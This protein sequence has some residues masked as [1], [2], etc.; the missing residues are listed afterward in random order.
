[1]KTTDLYNKKSLC[2]G[3]ELCSNVCPKHLII[4]K[5]DDE[6]FLY[7]NIINDEDCINCRR[8]LSV[9]PFKSPGRKNVHLGKS[10][11]GHFFNESEIKKSSSGGYATAISRGFILNGGMVIGVRYS[12]DFRSAEYAIVDNISDLEYFRTSKYIQALKG[13]V[14]NNLKKYRDRKILF[15]GLPCEVSAVYHCV[16][17]AVNNLYTISLICH[18]PTSCKIQQEFCDSLE[19]KFNSP[20]SFFSVRYKRNGWKPYFLRADFENGQRYEEK[21]KGSEY[22]M[23]FQYLKRPSCSNCK[24]KLGNKDFGLIADL[25]LGDFHAVE[26]TMP[27]YNKWGVSQLCIQSEKGAEL[28]KLMEDDCLIEPI[29]RDIIQTYNYAFHH[30][31]KPKKGS[32]QFKKKLIN[33]GLHKAATDFAILWDTHVTYLKRKLKSFVYQLTKHIIHK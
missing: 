13:E 7:P 12:N 4:M 11:G 29:Q 25:T 20:I 23:G 27:H 15:I 16:G 5:A 9:C 21:F 2:C 22:E 17:K 30:A 24:Y 14:Y 10:Y 18:G 31:V 3:C 1:M 32:E 8:C 33:M 28:L 6:G 19:R 26:K